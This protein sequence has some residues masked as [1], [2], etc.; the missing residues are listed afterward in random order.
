MKYNIGI[1]NSTIV[2]KWQHT[3]KKKKNGI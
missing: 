1:E 2:Q 3:L